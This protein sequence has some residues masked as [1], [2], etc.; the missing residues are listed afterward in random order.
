[1]IGKWFKR[2]GKRN[3]IFLATKFALV[4]DMQT[5]QFEVRG[6]PP[7]VRECVERSLKRLGVD[8]IDLYYY[9]R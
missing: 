4:V 1:V 8:Y 2:T 9:H 7:Y 3:Q 6:D 5:A